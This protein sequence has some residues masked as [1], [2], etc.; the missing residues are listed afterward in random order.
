MRT[1]RTVSI[2]Y[3]ANFL[4]ALSASRWAFASGWLM[5]AV[6]YA[7]MAGVPNSLWRATNAEKWDSPR[8]VSG[9]FCLNLAVIFLFADLLKDRLFP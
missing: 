7:I 2:L 8:W 1:Y 3:A 6:G 9:H 5:L 4:V